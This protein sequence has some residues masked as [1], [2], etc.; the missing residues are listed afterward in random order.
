[1]YNIV[2]YCNCHGIV[3]KYLFQTYFTSCN[4]NLLSNYPISNDNFKFNSDE[5]SIFQD[6]DLFIYQPMNQEWKSEKNINYVKTLLKPSCKSIK[7]AYYRFY[8][9]YADYTED[10]FCGKFIINKKYNYYSFYN[11]FCN[12]L[13]KFMQLDENSD[14]KIY[15]YFINNYKKIKLFVDPRHPTPI[16]FYNIFINMCKHHNINVPINYNEKTYQDLKKMYYHFK[17]DAFNIK[18]SNNINLF[19]NLKYL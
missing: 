13:H 2:I 9:L 7:I 3:Y 5:K 15:A 16:F 19:L 6:A 11:D 18:I 14:I 12:N 17:L 1:M 4:V 10:K 8:G